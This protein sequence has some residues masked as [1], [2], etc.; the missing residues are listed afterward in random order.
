MPYKSKQKDKAVRW[1][2]LPQAVEYIFMVDKC[3][4]SEAQEQLRKAFGERGIFLEWADKKPTSTRLPGITMPHDMPRIGDM[5]YWRTVP[6]DW[7]TGKVSKRPLLLSWHDLRK[8]WPQIHNDKNDHRRGRRKG[9]GAVD[10][11]ELLNEMKRLVKT[12]ISYNQAS[13]TVAKDN[14][15][16]SELATA[17]RI[18]KKYRN[19]IDAAPLG[20]K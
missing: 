16:H 11:T 18:R 8:H 6:I 2:T 19:W 20:S 3:T 1:A 12:G 9:S 10:D 4:I 15:G 7:E 14:S 5:E 17:E 13:K